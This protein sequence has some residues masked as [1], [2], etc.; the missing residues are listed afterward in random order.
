MMKKLSLYACLLLLISTTVVTAQNLPTNPDPGKCYVK[1]ITKDVFDTVTETVQVQ[2]AYQTLSVVPA[3]YKT[4]EERVLVKEATKRY[5]FVP[6]VYETVDV[7]YTTGGGAEEL[8]VIPV[9]VISYEFPP[10][11]LVV[12]MFPS[13]PLGAS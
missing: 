3:T 13:K 5:S 10:T 2:P 7:S 12:V 8:T 4:V 1:C 6:A 11:A 9:Q